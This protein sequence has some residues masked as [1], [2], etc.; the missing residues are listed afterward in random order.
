MKNFRLYFCAIL[1]ILFAFSA[2]A[3]GQKT[4]DNKNYDAQLAKK[5][6]ADDYGMKSYVFVILKTGE[7]KITDQKKRKELFDGHFSNMGR[8]AKEGKMVL[9]G[10]FVE[11]GEKRGLFILNTKSIEEAKQMVESDPAVKAGIFDYELTKYYGS[12]ALMQINE[13]HSKLQKTPVN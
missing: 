7:A 3:F 13:I 9:A 6:G 1:V 10:P 12:A 2:I 4:A 11:G 5:L 8:L